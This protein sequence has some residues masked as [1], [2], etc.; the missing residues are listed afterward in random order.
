MVK[1]F[2]DI[3]TGDPDDIMALIYL[4]GVESIEIVGIT[5]LPGSQKQIDLVKYILSKFSG[6]QDIPIG[7]YNYDNSNLSPWYFKAFG[8][9]P[10]Y[11]DKTIPI[12]AYKLMLKY[13][14]EN[15]IL[16]TGA[17][18]KNL[19]KAIENGKLTL[20]TWMAQGGFAGC[21]VVPEEYILEKFKNK[22]TFP[23]YNFGG[24]VKETEKALKYDG[25]KKRYMCSKNVCH[26]VLYDD[27]FKYMME[28]Y[29]KNNNNKNTNKYISIKLI[30]D[31]MHKGYG[32]RKDK[33]D[34]KMHDLL[35][36]VCISYPDVCE[37]A[38]VEP[39]HE[40]RRGGNWGSNPKEGTN[41]FISINY[42]KKLFLECLLKD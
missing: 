2:V 38:E 13:C 27:Q 32:N 26:N 5:L 22:V 29:I 7:S 8:E 1:V 15:T 28:S 42:N 37:W 6:K 23:T 11:K 30:Y 35:P 41:T 19:G 16:F 14:D 40:Q 9:I 25:I 3:E 33:G 24:S 12:D 31:S 10:S 39:Y 17:P 36:A 4:L 18:N 20:N 34:K 21:N